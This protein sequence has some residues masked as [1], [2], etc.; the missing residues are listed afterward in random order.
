[1]KIILELD[2]YAVVNLL[3]A[4]K[5]LPNTGNWYNDIVSKLNE[6]PDEYK[7][8]I[9][10]SGID[11][12]HMKRH[13]AHMEWKEKHKLDKHINLAYNKENHQK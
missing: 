13:I 12:H 11:L 9:H 4:L 2:D 8:N 7:R 5:F 3:H 6:F 10:N 1:M